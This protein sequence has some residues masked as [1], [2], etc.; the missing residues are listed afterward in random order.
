MK[1]PSRFTVLLSAGCLALSVLGGCA[2]HNAMHRRPSTSAAYKSLYSRLGRKAGITKV[3]NAFVARVAK[4]NRIN[5]KFKH[6]NIPHLKKQLVAFFGHLTGGPEVYTGK[7]MQAAHRGMNITEAQWKAFM[8]DFTLTL[9]AEKVSP[10]AQA[11]LL[12][13][14][15]PMKSDIVHK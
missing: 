10:T 1:T 2:K 7:D 12:G 14:M 3:V 11:E 6:T 5:G 13:Q 4:D 9:K 8:E 15:E